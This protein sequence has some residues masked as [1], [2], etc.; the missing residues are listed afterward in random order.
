MFGI[1]Q[2]FKHQIFMHELE[3]SFKTAQKMGIKECLKCG[4]C[5]HRRP[6]IPTPNEVEKI[7]EF[8]NLSVIDLIEKYFCIDS[9]FFK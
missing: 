6:C 5:C 7:A 9:Y 2:K 3:V 4:F 8:F 1:F